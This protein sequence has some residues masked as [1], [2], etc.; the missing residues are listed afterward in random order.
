[1]FEKSLHDNKNSYLRM[2]YV[3][4]MF[5]K[6]IPYCKPLVNRAYSMVMVW[7]YVFFTQRY[8]Q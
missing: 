4:Y 3:W 8:S 5:T 6:H 1:M 2:V 7:G